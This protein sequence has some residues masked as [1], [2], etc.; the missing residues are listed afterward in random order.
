VARYTNNIPFYGDVNTT[1]NMIGQSLTS[2]GF[3]YTQYEGEKVFKKGKGF[4]VA[5]TFVK[6]SF[7]NGMARVESWIKYALFPGVYIG[8]YGMTGMVGAAAKGPMK[9]A[10]QNV[11]S[12]IQQM[13][14]TATLPDQNMSMNTGSYNNNSYSQPQVKKQFC[15]RCGTEILD[16]SSFCSICGNPL[17]RNSNVPP[18]MNSQPQEQATMSWDTYQTQNAYQ[19]Q[20]TY[21]TQDA[22]QGMN[23]Q[24]VSRKEFVENYANP[25][26]KKDLKSLAILCYFCSGIT[27]AL[28]M[29]MNPLA[30]IDAL[31]LLGFT[32]GMHLAKSKACAILI[33][34]LSIYEVLYAII[35]TGTASGIWWLIAGIWSVVVFNKI[36]KEYNA[37]KTGQVL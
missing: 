10:V 22:Y 17:N 16:N 34:L 18:Q 12:I 31:L 37:F 13:M 29:A 1:F 28:A 35:L 24:N 33:L 21:Q 27:A 30:L 19:T 6:V 2:S 11:E 8:E 4:F 15:T 25:S 26:F 36:D 9:K 5:P 23:R 3:E 20:N 7:A 32:L 14:G